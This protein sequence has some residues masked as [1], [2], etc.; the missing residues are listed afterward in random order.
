MDDISLFIS[1]ETTEKR[2]YL[3]EFFK[4]VKALKKENQIVDVYQLGMKEQP[5]F[6]RELYED[7]PLPEEKCPRKY[8]RIGP[9]F[10]VDI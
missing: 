5:N 3:I 4:R 9:E 8:I 7:D 6:W 10:Q 2:K 1:L